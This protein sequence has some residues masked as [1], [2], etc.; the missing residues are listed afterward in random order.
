[1]KGYLKHL[2]LSFFALCQQSETLNSFT[3]NVPTLLL[4]FHNLITSYSKEYGG[5]GGGYAKIFELQCKNKIFQEMQ[6]G[7]GVPTLFYYGIMPRLQCKNKS[8]N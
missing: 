8:K 6:G 1:M 5:G 3:R 4:Y 2:Y 7:G